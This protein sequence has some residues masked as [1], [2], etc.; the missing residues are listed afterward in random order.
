M[1]ITCGPGWINV[2][3]TR[4][5]LESLAQK[6]LEGNLSMRRVGTHYTKLRLVYVPIIRNLVPA[7]RIF[8]WE[9]GE[10]FLTF[11]FNSVFYH[12]LSRQGSIVERS[13]YHVN[14]TLED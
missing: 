5:E 12:D 8:D 2:E 6:P 11:T 3:I 4:Q 13:L 1:K 9:E 10:E 14:I 7:S